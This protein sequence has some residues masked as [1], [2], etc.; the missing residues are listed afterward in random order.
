MNGSLALS[1]ISQSAH[2]TDFR[3]SRGAFSSALQ[4]E[5]ASRGA[6]FG[7]VVELVVLHVARPLRRRDSDVEQAHVPS[8]VG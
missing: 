1:K 2:H 8:H 4:G 3:S 6:E 5:K 7:P